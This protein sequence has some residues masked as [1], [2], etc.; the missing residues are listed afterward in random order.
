MKGGIA[1]ATTENT[2]PNTSDNSVE[3]ESTVR[4]EDNNQTDAKSH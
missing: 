4:T 2:V 1:V 3:M